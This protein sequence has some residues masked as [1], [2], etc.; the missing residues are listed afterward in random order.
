MSIHILMA[1][2]DNNLGFVLQDHLE[3][4]GYT[5]DRAMDG[6]EALRFFKE[7]PNYD[8]CVFDVMMPK[9]DGFTLTDEIRKNQSRYSGH[10]SDCK[11]YERG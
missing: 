9:M 6:E 7:Q 3:D 8:I 10:I 1:E 4:Q 11:E 5:V 2:D